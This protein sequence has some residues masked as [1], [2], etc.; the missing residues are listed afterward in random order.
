MYDESRH[1][2][3]EG[4]AV[5]VSGGG[6][7]NVAT[8]QWLRAGSSAVFSQVPH[9]KTLTIT[10]VVLNPQRDVTTVH[11]INLAE[12]TPNGGT[13]LFFQFMVAPS[14]TQQAHFLTGHVIE[15]GGEVV[16]FT[17]GNLPFGEHI[18]VSLNGYLPK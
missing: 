5:A 12:Q 11:T 13:R 10:D 18:S 1:V 17:D 14:A 6:I 2:Q 8:L 4:N 15:A 7:G 3:A 16:T 9:G